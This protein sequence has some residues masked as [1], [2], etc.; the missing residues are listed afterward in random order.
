[1]VLVLPSSCHRRHLFR[2]HPRHWPQRSALLPLVYSADLILLLTSHAS[3]RI[4]AKSVSC[5]SYTYSRSSQ[6]CTQSKP[7]TFRPDQRARQSRHCSLEGAMA[8]LVQSYSQQSAPVAMLQA[9]PASGSGLQSSSSHQ[10]SGSQTPRP[11]FQPRS[12]SG[13]GAAAYRNSG[14]IKPYAFTSTPS[15]NTGS[16]QQQV[17]GSKPS[18]TSGQPA[19]RVGDHNRMMAMGVGMSGS[20]DDSYLLQQQSIVAAQRPHSAYLTSSHVPQLS[21]SQPSPARASPDRYRRPGVAQHGRSASIQPSGSGMS[22]AGHL[23]AAPSPA[24]ASNRSS[25]PP[26]SRPS[27]MPG[28][29]VDDAEIHY[30]NIQEGNRL[31]RRSMHTIDSVDYPNPLTPHFLKQAEEANRLAAASSRPGKD[32]SKSARLSPNSAHR[33]SMH[34]RNNSSE[35]VASSRSSHSRPSVRTMLSSPWL[36]V[37]RVGRHCRGHCS[38]TRQRLAESTN[39]SLQ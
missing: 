14:P 37:A 21:P 5:D 36:F 18:P 29:A 10:Y 26:G 20:R 32:Y 24:P 38:L 3:I 8:T 23:Y 30:R 31:R 35:S 12:V 11:N 25:L 4:S 28:S 33:E 22:S 17:G 27:T 19:L 6:A 15:L 13:S 2:P 7:R 39:A 16:S 1:M 9:R 34:N